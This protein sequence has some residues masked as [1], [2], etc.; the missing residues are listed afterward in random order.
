MECGNRIKAMRAIMAVVMQAT[1]A[2]GGNRTQL[3]I[4]GHMA[5]A[6]QW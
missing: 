2:G 5:R 4:N 6:P 3:A 1:V